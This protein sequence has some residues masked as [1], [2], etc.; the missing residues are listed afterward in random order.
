MT[1]LIFEQIEELT[2]DQLKFIPDRIA[3]AFTVLRLTF[4]YSKTF[5]PVR[6]IPV[7][8]SGTAEDLF[9]WIAVLEV[10]AGIGRIGR[11]R[12]RHRR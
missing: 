1:R 12:L 11:I 2:E 4:E 5:D 8:I 9:V 10:V 6:V 7:R 3:R